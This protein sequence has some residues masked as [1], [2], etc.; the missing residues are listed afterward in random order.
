MKKTDLGIGELA[1]LA[2]NSVETIRYYEQRGL[3]KPAGRKA[4]GYRI[5]NDE[6]LK[7]LSFLKRAQNLG[8]SLSEIKELLRL[9]TSRKSCCD[10]VQKRAL[11]HLHNVEE[12]IEKLGVI[13]LELS[14]LLKQCHSN[15]E[16]DRC[17]ILD[18][19]D[20]IS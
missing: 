13:R 1:K 11:K 5:Y 18:R 16:P 12:K 10:N 4:S 20:Q 15:K 14:N 9:R 8:F 17:P 19:F 7:T 6:S 3:L 2:G